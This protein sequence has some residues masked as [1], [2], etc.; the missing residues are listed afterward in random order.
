[1]SGKAGRAPPEETR[2]MLVVGTVWSSPGKARSSSLQA[3]LLTV[4]CFQLRNVGCLGRF[5]RSVHERPP[6]MRSALAHP[7][8]NPR[9]L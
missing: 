9:F 1:M 5:C 4:L 6:R 7:P 3:R 2:P 8:R